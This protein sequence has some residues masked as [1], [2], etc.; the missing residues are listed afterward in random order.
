MSEDRQRFEAFLAKFGDCYKS[1]EVRVMC[2]S[3]GEEWRNI[4]THVE[5]RPESPQQF[6]PLPDLPNTDYFRAMHESLPVADA[7]KTIDAIGAGCLGVGGIDV[8]F[9]SDSHD[10]K[11]GLRLSGTYS[12]RGNA[13]VPWSH[14]YLWGNGPGVLNG[15]IDKAGYDLDLHLRGPR[16]SL[17]GLCQ[18]LRLFGRLDIQSFDRTGV[19]IC[20]PLMLRFCRDECESE[21]ERLLVSLEGVPP[22]TSLPSHITVVH[23]A[24]EGIS[25]RETRDLRENGW[26]SKGDLLVRSEVFRLRAGEGFM[27]TLSI[28]DWPADEITSEEDEPTEYDVREF[29][30]KEVWTGEVLEQSRGLS[31]LEEPPVRPSKSDEAIALARDVLEDLEGQENRRKDLSVVLRKARR[32]ADLEG[33]S[34]MRRWLRRELEG[35]DEEEPDALEFM[36]AAGRGVSDEGSYLTAPLPRL[37]R[38]VDRIEAMGGDEP[39]T[40]WREHERIQTVIQF[41]LSLL[42]DFA[43]SIYHKLVFSGQAESIFERYKALVD[44]RLADRCADIL[45]KMPTVD[46]RLADGDSEAV[47]HAMTTCRRIIAG[48][49]DALYPPPQEAVVRNGKEVELGSE[50][51]KNRLLEYVRERVTSDRRRARLRQT[52]N[53]L[54]GSVSTSVHGEIVPSE[55]R[56]L[57]LQTYLFL[58]EM[59]TLAE[60]SKKVNE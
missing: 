55:A 24:S 48:A 52:L 50:K 6:K 47:S 39:L 37:K 35:F 53:N 5:F 42:H 10:E 49:A 2:G 28:N 3:K 29:P 59:L 4:W 57:F 9:I 58:G 21:D 14:A 56:A 30:S 25:R 44:S 60:P 33:D 23:H 43:T 8:L 13:G 40:A 12:E 15:Y 54:W 38:A 20:A 17:G 22:F 32:L 31:V 18:Y 45:E 11:P 51:Q 46:E 41:S 19:R 16:H 1:V 7:A 34:K 36:R 26:E 27:A